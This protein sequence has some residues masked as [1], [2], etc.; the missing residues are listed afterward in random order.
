MWGAVGYEMLIVGM[1]WP[2]VILGF[3]FNVGKVLRG[4][5]GARASFALMAALTLIFWGLHYVYALWL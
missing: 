3:L 1:G 2:H 5:S 4:D